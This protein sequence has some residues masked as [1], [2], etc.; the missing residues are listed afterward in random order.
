MVREADGGSL[1]SSSR[2]AFG[3]FCERREKIANDEF[4]AIITPYLG[5]SCGSS[6]HFMD[7]FNALVVRHFSYRKHYLCRQCYFYLYNSSGG[8]FTS[9]GFTE[10]YA[11][12]V[13]SDNVFATTACFTSFAGLNS[14]SLNGKFLYR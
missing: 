5:R 2:L 3:Q 10:G 4:Q 13:S 1:S 12:K 14:G 6:Y 11:K 8:N 9:S 7:R